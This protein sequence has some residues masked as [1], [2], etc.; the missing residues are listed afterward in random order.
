MKKIN[1]KSLLI[2]LIIGGILFSGITVSAIEGL[3]VNPNPFPIL[4]DGV[5]TEVEAYNINGYTYLKLAEVGKATNA[6]VK[7]NEVDRQIEVQKN[8]NEIPITFQN[9]EAISRN[10]E[11]YISLSDIIANKDDL[12]SM[13]GITILT[14]PTPTPIPVATPTPEPTPTESTQSMEQQSQTLENT[15]TPTPDPKAALIAEENARHEAVIAQIQAELNVHSSIEW[16]TIQDL[17]DNYRNIEED[18]RTPEMNAYIQEA[19]KWNSLNQSLNSENALHTQ[20]L[21]NIPE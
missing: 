5:V 21:A 10:S 11:L 20:N 8:A 7:F 1:F 4:I 17:A 15:S 19:N 13:M 12:L 9:M 14:A 6:S 3:N 18:A 2:G 16:H